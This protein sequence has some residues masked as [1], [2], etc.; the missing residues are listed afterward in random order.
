MQRRIVEPADVSGNALAELKSWLG[1]TRPAEDALLMDLLH[2][3]LSMCESFTGQA[4]LSQLVEERLPTAATKVTLVSRPISSISDVEL[5]S[6]NGDRTPI[7]ADQYDLKTS[8][9]A[10]L[11]FQLTKGLE[12]QAVIVTA[13]VGIADTWDTVPAALKQGIIRLCAYHYRDRDRPG[14]GGKASSPPAIVSALWRP[15]QERRLT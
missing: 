6:H 10:T 9:Q 11:V 15:W 2:M 13:R 12:G 5:V 1:I 3:A 7:T 14:E 4:P 8:P